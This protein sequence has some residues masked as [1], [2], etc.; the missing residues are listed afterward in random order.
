MTSV[1]DP[2][3]Y[4]DGLGWMNVKTGK[5][6]TDVEVVVATLA[7]S[8]DPISPAYLSPRQARDYAVALLVAASMAE[9]INERRKYETDCD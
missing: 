4:D 9:E 3:Y 6:H 2:Y 8:E 1:S 5:Y 7:S